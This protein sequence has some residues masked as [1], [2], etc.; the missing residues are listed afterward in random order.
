MYFQ[1]IRID[2][3]FA[4]G[5]TLMFTI[6]EM[7]NCSRFRLNFKFW[8]LYQF[9]LQLLHAFKR[10]FI[11][12]MNHQLLN[13]VIE[14]IISFILIPNFST[15][16]NFS[17]LYSWCLARL[18]RC[19]QFPFIRDFL[20]LLF[21]NF[22]LSGEPVWLIF[23]PVPSGLWHH[24]VVFKVLYYLPS[25]EDNII[26][27]SLISNSDPSHRRRVL[28][29]CL[30]LPFLCLIFLFDRL[31]VRFALIS[32]PFWCVYSSYLIIKKL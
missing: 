2:E 31:A 20:V 18:L 10:T 30:V 32:H 13:L 8:F 11:D 27:S 1:C 15:G 24:D 16:T 5:W 28:N 29:D 23:D 3:E 12:S 6:Q 19:F 7:K 25:L 21:L 9:P 4:T 14:D 17:C 22:N 26:F